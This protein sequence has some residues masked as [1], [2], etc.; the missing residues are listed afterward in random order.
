MGFTYF[1]TVLNDFRLKIFSDAKYVFF[2]CLRRW[3][4]GLKVVRVNYFQIW[5]INEYNMV[6]SR[7]ISSQISP[8]Y[9]ETLFLYCVCVKYLCV[10]VSL[11]EG[12]YIYAQWCKFKISF[13]SADG[14]VTLI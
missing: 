2:F 8:M 1:E 10:S 13:L 9:F 6:I 3:D 14:T 5:N 12:Q 4:R 11:C 7:V